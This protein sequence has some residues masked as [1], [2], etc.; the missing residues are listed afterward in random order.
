MMRLSR[1]VLAL[2]APLALAACVQ[3]QGPNDYTAF[4]AADPHSIAIVPAVNRSLEVTAADYYLSTISIPLAERGY[5][6]FPVHLVKRVMED[7][8]LSDADLVHSAPTEQVAALFGADA[9]LYVTIQVWESNY[10]IFATSTRVTL[11][12]A[13]K[14]GA[15][16][17]EL[18]KDTEQMEY[19]PQSS[20]G[21]IAGLIAQA[22]AA[23]AERAAPNYMPLARQANWM[24]VGRLGR[25]LP[26]GPY[27]PKYGHDQDAFPSAQKV[28]PKKA[29]ADPPAATPAAATP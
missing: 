9:V 11:D 28:E 23:A 16:G 27:A 15:T 7:D 24:A 22:I 12:Y 4:R 26:D 10:A 19:H 13:L 14:D 6:V 1:P 21:G 25:G 2:L 8:G 18:W 20:G 29:E 5:Y 3:P 17:E